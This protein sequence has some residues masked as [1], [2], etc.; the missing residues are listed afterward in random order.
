MF[1]TLK[2]QRYDDIFA[3]RTP[4]HQLSITSSDFDEVDDD[5]NIEHMT[6]QHFLAGLNVVPPSAPV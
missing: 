6:P 4:A 1:G 3:K 2:R 5:E